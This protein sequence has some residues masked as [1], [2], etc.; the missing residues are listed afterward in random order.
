MRCKKELERESRIILQIMLKQLH[1]IKKLPFN[2]VALYRE[3]PNQ[4]I[5]VKKLPIAII[6]FMVKNG[7]LS[8]QGENYKPTIIGKKWLENFLYFIEINMDKKMTNEKQNTPKSIANRANVAMLEIDI[9]PI[10]KLYNRQRNI[11]YKYLK[12][13]H[14]YAGQ[15]LFKN[16]LNANLQPNITMDW[17]KLNSVKQNHYMGKKESGFSENNYIARTKL[18]D[19]L[20]H[21]GEEFSAILVEICIFGNGLEATE[22]TMNWPAR[23]GKLLLTLALDK[24][25][26]FYGMDQDEKEVNK[27]LYWAKS[28]TMI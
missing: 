7:W 19:S 24:L 27:Y 26:D 9:S 28:E 14:L 17:N 10:V 20:K 13:R 16:F 2:E 21:V 23:S 22:K 6:E 8:Y 4:K 3:K 25:A 1:Y 11:A 12:E 5:F 15:R 18:Y